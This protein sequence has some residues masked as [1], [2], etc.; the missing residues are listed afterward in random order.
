MVLVEQKS[1][2]RYADWPPDSRRPNIN[3]DAISARSN[4]ISEED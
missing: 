4:F 1:R 2:G 3:L